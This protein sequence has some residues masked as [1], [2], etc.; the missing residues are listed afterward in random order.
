MEHKDE[1]PGTG[2]Q[3]AQFSRAWRAW[4]IGYIK[5]K[6]QQRKAKRENETPTDRAARV[7]ASATVWIAFFTVVSASVGIFTFCVLR[8]QLQE[9]HQSGIDTHALAGA[10]SD[11]ANA[12]SDQADAAQ[13]F[14]DTAEDINGGIAGAVGQLEAAAGNAKAGIRA[15][16]AAMRL[17]QRAWMGIT[18][19]SGKPEEGKPF[20]ISISFKN[21]GRTPARHVVM[22]GMYDPSPRGGKP[23]FPLENSVANKLGEIPPNGDRNFVLHPNQGVKLSKIDVDTVLGI[24]VWVHGRLTYD[25]VFGRPHWLTYCVSMMGDSGVYGFCDE[26]NESDEDQKTN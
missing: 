23:R 14:S 7:T 24:T 2:S 12:A 8:N 6:F 19:V 18:A 11:A 26:H 17:D 13:Q 15:T 1:G 22:Y 25:D 21:S 4:L 10:A 9:M 3:I 16:Q 5:S 20:D